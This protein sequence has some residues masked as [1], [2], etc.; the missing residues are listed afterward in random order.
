MNEN[1]KYDENGGILNTQ[2]NISEKAVVGKKQRSGYNFFEKLLLRYSRKVN[3]LLDE[4]GRYISRNEKLPP[5]VRL[6]PTNRC[7]AQC[8]YCPREY[9]SQGGTGYMDWEMFKKIVDWAKASHVS[10][11]GFALFG[12]PLIHPRIVE[13]INYVNKNGFSVRFSTNG[14]AL[15]DDLT[16]KILKFP[17]SAIEI[18]MDGFNNREYYAGKQVNQY[19]KAKNNVLNLLKLAKTEGAKTLFNIHYVDI[20]NVSFFNRLKFVRFW[21][22]ELTG[23]NYATSFVYEPH[24]WAGTRD[25]LR[26]MMSLLDQWLSKWELKKP[27]AYLNGLNIDWN[28]DVYVCTGD[29]TSDAI[30][31]NINHIPIEEIYNSDRRMYYLREHEKGSFKEINCQVCTMNSLLPLL[32]LKKKLI[33]F[34]I[35]LFV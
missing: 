32:F 4:Q 10:T 17:I 30:I 20:G 8:F 12:E 35:S 33:N 5:V 31:G 18:S 11:I 7:T 24:N 2:E 22:K 6:G 16:E 14:I 19:E 15:T 1:I 29:P 28:G 27:C 13:M 25:N 3:Y 26:K 9:V 23:L 21:K 34:L